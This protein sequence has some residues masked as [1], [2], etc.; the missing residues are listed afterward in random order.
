LGVK[1]GSWLGKFGEF[2]MGCLRC[3]TPQG[4]R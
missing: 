2:D 1:W 4:V 3:E